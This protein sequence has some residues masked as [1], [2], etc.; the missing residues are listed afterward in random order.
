MNTV[1]KV[2]TVTP[3]EGLKMFLHEPEIHLE[4]QGEDYALELGIDE[5]RVQIQFALQDSS[6]TKAEVGY[7]KG[8]ALT[9]ET[10][11][12]VLPKYQHLLGLLRQCKEKSLA[13]SMAAA[14]QDHALREF[15]LFVE[16]DVRRL[17]ARVLMIVVSIWN[18]IN[19]RSPFIKKHLLQGF[20]DMTMMG[21]IMLRLHAEIEKQKNTYEM[22]AKQT[23]NPPLSELV[24]VMKEI[25]CTLGEIVTRDFNTA[26]FGMQIIEI[27]R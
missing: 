15:R 17:I 18:L 8:A 10:I 16:P 2:T 6:Q 21:V 25:T 3:T 7:E 19:F 14:E 27:I 22:E 12:E 1:N 26:K 20:T 11:A 4:A 24:M 5:T 13:R 23:S 9:P